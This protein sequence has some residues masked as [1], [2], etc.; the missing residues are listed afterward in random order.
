MMKM[1]KGILYLFA[2]LLPMA[3]MTARAEELPTDASGAYLISNVDDW[4]TFC[5]NVNSGNRNYNGK[6]VKLTAD[7]SGATTMAG[8]EEH[9]FVGGVSHL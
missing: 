5:N 9:P 7:I 8:T 2:L 4:T 3:A 1:R 6:T